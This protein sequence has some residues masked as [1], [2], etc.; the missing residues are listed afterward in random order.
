MLTLAGFWAVLKTLYIYPT[1]AFTRLL[2]SR[3]SKARSSFHRQLPADGSA[4]TYASTKSA[5]L[6]R[7]PE[8]ANILHA[9]Q[10]QHFI[11][12]G[13]AVCRAEHRCNEVTSFRDDFVAGHG[14]L[15]RTANVAD[16]LAH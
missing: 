14:I 3:A 6:Q 13:Q 12:E 10:G 11:N 15:G 8:P 9:F 16:P 5:P 4:F 2:K 7:R 1:I